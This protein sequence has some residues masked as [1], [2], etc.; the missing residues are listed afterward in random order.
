MQ[1]QTVFLHMKSVLSVHF[2][3]FVWLV[4]AIGHA[5][6]KIPET[7]CYSYNIYYLNSSLDANNKIL[8]M[9]YHKIYYLYWAKYKNKQ[10]QTFNINR[11][12]R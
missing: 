2:P 12:S 9:S 10:H 11:K 7:L 4:K 6:R 1:K 5:G 3:L 8:I